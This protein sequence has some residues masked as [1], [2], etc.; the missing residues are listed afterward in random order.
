M[1]GE[2]VHGRETW[3]RKGMLATRRF[4]SNVA[5]A[6]MSL[7]AGIERA[8]AM[9]RT[10]MCGTNGV[11]TSQQQSKPWSPVASGIYLASSSQQLCIPEVVLEEEKKEVSDVITYRH[12][13]RRYRQCSGCCPRGTVR[14]LSVRRE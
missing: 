5:P 8:G 1:V 4:R 2:R 12:H 11:A 13:H 6:G 7:L 9:G 3:G 10:T 14:R